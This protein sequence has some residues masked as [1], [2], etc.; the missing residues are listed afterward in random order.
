MDAR[1]YGDSLSRSLVGLN[2][3]TETGETWSSGVEIS[4]HLRSEFGLDVHWRTIDA[5]FAKNK[6]L[7]A[8][9]KRKGRWEYMLLDAGHDVLAGGNE[10]ITFIDPTASLQATLRL[11]DFLANLKGTI[12]VCDPYLDEATIEH[13]QACSTSI[14]VKLL[15][16]N[17]RD[18]GPLRRLVAAAKTA[19]YQFE[20]RTVAARML[21]DRYIIDDATMVILGTSLN[22]FGKKQSFVIQAGE[23]IRAMVLPEFEAQWLAATAWP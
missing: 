17:V 13:L 6:R 5:L 10:A 11:H 7:A 8:R 12:R 18:T 20:I 22:G 2:N 1:S 3:L 16:M 4:W 9:R 14:P 15:T 21:H 19:G 23:D